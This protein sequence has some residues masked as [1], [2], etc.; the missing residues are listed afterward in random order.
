LPRGRR[1]PASLDVADVHAVLSVDVVAVMG[2]VFA[3]NGQAIGFT[4]D[5]PG[6]VE[7]RGGVVYMK[8]PVERIA[9]PERK[10]CVD[11]GSWSKPCDCTCVMVVMTV[12]CYVC[13]AQH[14]PRVQA[15]RVCEE[16]RRRYL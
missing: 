16:C 11:C 2:T 3:S 14:D 5:L 10:A 4:N 13:D 12:H 6:D 9:A 8:P 15:P 1:A 7:I